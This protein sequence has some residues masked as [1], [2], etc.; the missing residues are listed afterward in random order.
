[1]DATLKEWITRP[2]IERMFWVS[3]NTCA[4]WLSE[5]K[6]GPP[7]GEVPNK[8]GQGR[9]L[10]M[11]SMKKVLEVYELEYIAIAQRAIARGADRT[12]FP[13]YLEYIEKNNLRL[14][15]LEVKE[16]PVQPVVLW[17]WCDPAT[18]MWGLY[19]GDLFDVDFDPDNEPYYDGLPKIL[20]LDNIDKSLIPDKPDLWDEAVSLLC[21]PFAASNMVT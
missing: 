1:M 19:S 20:N 8:S 5:G 21:P 3:T 18:D 12:A 9:Q 11:Y 6:F 7:I 2:E 16:E 17:M 13:E 10:N 14:P 4:R 15:T